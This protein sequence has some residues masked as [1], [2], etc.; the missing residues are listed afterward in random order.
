MVADAI[1]Q[2]FNFDYHGSRNASIDYEKEGVLS[3]RKGGIPD[4]IFCRVDM[5]DVYFCS[6]AYISCSIVDT[7]NV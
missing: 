5:G 1:S 3:W 7:K 4:I 2:N 6:D